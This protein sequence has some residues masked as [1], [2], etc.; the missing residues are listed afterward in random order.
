M[1]GVG[2]QWAHL[3]QNGKTTDSFAGELAGDFMFWPTKGT[4]L[5]GTWSQLTITVSPEVISSR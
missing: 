2:P 1:L 5:A 3:K 4:V